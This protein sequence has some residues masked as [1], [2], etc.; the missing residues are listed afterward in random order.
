MT[1]RP[2]FEHDLQH[3]L[4]NRQKLQTN[5]NLLYWYQQLY[6]EMFSDIEGI[7]SKRVLEI[8][9]GTSPLSLFYPH[10]LTSD[11]MPL[12]YLDYVFD[13]HAIDH[14]EQIGD[15]SL[16]IITLTNVL[17]HL[18]EPLVFLINSAIKLKTG[19]QIIVAE[20]YFST[21]SAWI[22]SHFH[23]EPSIFDI[24]DPV[25]EKIEGPLSSANQAIPYMLF[26]R[27]TA[28]K[29]ALTEHYSYSERAISYFSGI[30][31]MATGGISRAFPIP[32]PVYQLFFKLDRTLSMI[33]P[34]ILSSFFIVRLIKR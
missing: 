31:Y 1:S 28:W 5:K 20:P 33:F 21:V 25:L 6:E 34:H 22:F 13:A 4:A 29:E 16:D 32:H 18:Q 26:F 2:L 27:K 8:G 10:V 14:V 30:S 12:E 15:E 3:T 9:S 24:T 11:I 7:H 17:H 19:G 23:P